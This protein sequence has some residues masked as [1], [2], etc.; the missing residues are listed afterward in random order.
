MKEK[1]FKYLDDLME[2]NIT[3]MYGATPYI[4]AKFGLD[5][6]VARNYLTDWMIRWEEGGN[7]GYSMDEK[8]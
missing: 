8:S 1:V 5:K 6:D 7:N 4:R 2:S 3:N